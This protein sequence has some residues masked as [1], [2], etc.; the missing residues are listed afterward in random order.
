MPV[1]TGDSRR[2]RG[3]MAPHAGYMASG[4]NAAHAYRALKEDGLPE[5]YVVIGPDHYGTA[6]GLSLIHI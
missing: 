1:H 5:A 4:M 2:I 3:I 6:S